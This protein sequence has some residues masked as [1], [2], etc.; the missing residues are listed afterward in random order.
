MLRCFRRVPLPMPLLLLPLG[1]PIALGFSQAAAAAGRC[2]FLAPIGGS[3]A[4]P[5]VEKRVGPPKLS[6]LGLVLGRTNW[7]TDFV[8]DRPYASYKVFFTASS[9]DPGAEYP[10][11]GFM[12]FSDGSSL[13][14]FSASMQ[15]PVGTG[16]MFGPFPAVPGKQAAQMNV[17][18]GTSTNPKAI[19]FSYRISVQ[20]C[21]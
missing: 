21:D 15:P 6:P 16:R 17:K 1:L 18:V 14:L 13:E 3:G 7:N 10:V 5:V 19:G 12:K 4:S 8:V 20:G 2:T 11:A 9:S